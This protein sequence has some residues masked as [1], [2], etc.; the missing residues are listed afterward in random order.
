MMNKKKS[1]SGLKTYYGYLKNSIPY[2]W[3]TGKKDIAISGFLATL[4]VDGMFLHETVGA[5]AILLIFMLIMDKMVLVLVGV[6][7]LFIR[8]LLP[9][10]KLAEY[11]DGYILETM[12][13][14]VI[15]ALAQRVIVNAIAKFYF[16]EKL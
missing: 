5:S 4:A 11:I 8:T 10:E 6:Y 13:F 7:F 15:A 12:L 14:F 1:S 16:N 2:Y 9:F 3:Y